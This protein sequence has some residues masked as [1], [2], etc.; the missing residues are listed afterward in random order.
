MV[1]T[2]APAQQFAERNGP[3]PDR[4]GRGGPGAAV[5]QQE[6]VRGHVLK[7]VHVCFRPVL[8]NNLYLAVA[9]MFKQQISRC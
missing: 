5:V 8:T 6:E 1:L 7:Q 9:I 4:H 3:P 2:A